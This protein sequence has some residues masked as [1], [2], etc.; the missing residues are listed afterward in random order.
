MKILNIILKIIGI[1]LLIIGTYIVFRSAFVIKVIDG[2]MYDGFG[3]LLNDKGEHY[4]I[5]NI[6][7]YISVFLTYGI[8]L[9]ILTYK[10]D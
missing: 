6:F 8:G 7:I 3:I 1:L 4:F 10:K 5:N 2:V 9:S